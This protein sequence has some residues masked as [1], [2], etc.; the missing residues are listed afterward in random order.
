MAPLVILQSSDWHVGSPLTGRGLGLTEELRARRR[1]EV[2]AAPERLVGAAR[3]VRPDVVLLPGDLWDVE[4]VP[5]ALFRRL[6]E[7]FAALAPAPVFVA[8]G[9]HDFAGA[10]GFYDGAFLEALGLPEW[11]ANV[12]VFRNPSWETFP[13]PGRADAAVTGRA[14]LSP[15]LEEGRPLDPAPRRPAVP[16]ALLLLHGSLESYRGPDAPVGGKKTA[17]FSLEELERARFDWAALGHH[18]ALE[19]V[20]GEDG[21]PLGAYSG[22][23]TGRGLD[24]TGPRRF[25]KVTLSEESPPAVETLAADAR[26]VL[27]LVLDAGGREA[28]ALREAALALLVESGA[29]P[30]DVVR[31]TLGGRPGA[32]TRAAAALAELKGLVA[33]LVL[34]DRT[35]AEP[36]ARADRSTAEGRFALDLEARLAAAP[37]ERSRR[38]LELAR[39]LGREALLGRLPA[40]PPLEEF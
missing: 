21:R 25:L 38:V 17:P 32:G 39:S 16:H 24:E 37:D 1:E 18:H 9:N 3:E 2:D 22:S 29:T 31:L 36:E 35:A 19:V 14:Y 4:N 12:T 30:A 6:V 13:V 28:E 10:D 15:L 5:P 34:R 27:D 23:P 11:P 33:H 40:P 8:P 26:Q 20:F 7:A